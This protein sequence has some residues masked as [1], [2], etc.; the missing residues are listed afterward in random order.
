MKQSSGPISRRPKRR[1]KATGDFNDGTFPTP[2]VGIS[3][4]SVGSDTFK[5]PQKTI[6]NPE[7]DGPS[8]PGTTKLV[9][10]SP[11]AP[12]PVPGSLID[13]LDAVVA[14]LCG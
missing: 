4:W 8:C 7:P 9:Q 2:F 6:R 12:K 14:P 11:E 1:R 13:P 10:R 3:K 5:A